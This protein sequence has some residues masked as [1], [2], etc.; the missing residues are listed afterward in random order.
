VFRRTIL[1]VCLLALLSVTVVAAQETPVTGNAPLN[2]DALIAQ[3]QAEGEISVIVGLAAGTQGIELPPEAVAAQQD[4]IQSARANVISSLAAYGVDIIEPSTQWQI[5]FVA[6]RVNAAGLAALA[7]NPL[8]TSIHPDEVLYSTLSGTIPLINADDVWTAG[9]TGAGQSVVVID[10]GVDRNHAFFGGRVVAEACFSGGGSTT[11][12]LCPNLAT[13][14]IGIGASSP[15]RCVSSGYTDCDHGTHVAG[16]AAGSGGSFSGVAKGANII[17]I[18]TAGKPSSGDRVSHYLSDIVSGLDHAYSLRNTY[19][20]AS[21]NMSLG[22]GGFSNYCDATYPAFQASMLNLRGARIATVVATGNNGFTGSIST[23]ACLS[24][25]ISVGATTDADAIASFSNRHPIMTVFA[26]G[27]D[28]NSSYIGGIY[29]SISGTSMATPHVAGAAA[30][31]KQAKPSMTV[32]EFKYALENTGPDIP[33]TGAVERRLDVQAALSYVLNQV[34]VNNEFN[35]G[36]ANWVPY[37]AGAQTTRIQNGVYEFYRNAGSPAASVIQTTGVAIPAVGTRF[38]VHALLGNSSA[39]PQRISILAY[40]ADFSDIQICSFWLPANAPLRD[41]M[42]QFRN[43]DAWTN[44]TIAFYPAQ[45]NNLAWLRMDDIIMTRIPG[46]WNYT[47]CEDPLA[48]GPTGG[49]SANLLSNSDFSLTVPPPSGNANGNWWTFGQI[50]WT[51]SAGAFNFNRVAGTPAGLVAQNSGDA[52]P[53]NTL[54]EAKFKLGNSSS[55]RGQV[56][57]I[58]HDSDFTDMNVCTFWLTPNQPLTSYTMFMYAREA[59]TNATI[60]FYPRTIFPSGSFIVDDVTMRT[61]SIGALGTECYPYNT[62]FSLG[63]ERADGSLDS[64]AE[65]ELNTEIVIPT[66]ESPAAPIL[67]PGEL[68]IIATPVPFDASAGQPSGEGQQVEGELAEGG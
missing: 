12:S 44:A 51:Q 1:I 27:V 55:S 15:S 61:R 56:T 42:M 3:A 9:Y 31:L 24:A 29:A 67:P 62:L 25:A 59:W 28:V 45:A 58:I 47:Y 21:V 32:S 36:A 41:Y 13:T 6:L 5:P 48:P 39:Q 46:T 14:Q 16:I 40:D 4:E 20:I 34:I 22:G 53:I 23:P 63:S 50:N 8:V 68:P 57:V 49:D 26:P 38:E 18:M 52:A 66:L 19:S 54:F 64:G 7:E 33:I 35:S 17:S 37:P 10:S 65:V 60:S 11:F 2:V 43:S 30:L